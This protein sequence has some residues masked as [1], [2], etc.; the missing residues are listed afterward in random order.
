MCE[1]QQAQYD[2]RR[3]PESPARAALAMPLAQSFENSRHQLLIIE[4]CIGVRHPIFAQLRHFLGNQTL[5]K[6]ELLATE[7]NHARFSGRN[8][9]TFNSLMASR[10]SFTLR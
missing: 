8:D 2:L 9:W 3:N 5:A 10:A 1:Q 4:K 7:F 6:A